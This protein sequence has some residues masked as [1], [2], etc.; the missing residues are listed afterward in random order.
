M[1]L[2]FR[3]SFKIAPGVRLNV[4]K[5]G[6]SSVSIGG[7]GVKVNVGKKGTRTTLSAPGTGLSYSTYKP[8]N[9]NN[10]N[11]PSPDYSNPN[12]FM[13]YSKLEWIAGAIVGFIF[14]VG[15]IWLI[16]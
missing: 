15:F 2:N 4:D 11:Q 12:N 13:G 14:F 6:L 8:H 7:K 3:K 5:K 16:S 10:T 1:G 9:K